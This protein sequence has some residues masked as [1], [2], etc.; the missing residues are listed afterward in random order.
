MAEQINLYKAILEDPSKLERKALELVKKIPAFQDFFNGNS[1][2][3]SLFRLPD[4]LWICG[5]SRGVADAEQRSGS[6][7]GQDLISRRPNAAAMVTTECT[8]SAERS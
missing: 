5:Q 2:L 3:A 8:S 1:E 7:T 6:D 4:K